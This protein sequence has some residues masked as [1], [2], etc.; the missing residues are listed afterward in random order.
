MCRIGTKGGYHSHYGITSVHVRDEIH[1]EP[2]RTDVCTKRR[3][4]MQKCTIFNHFKNKPHYYCFTVIILYLC[5]INI[6]KILL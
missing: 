2:G 4:T 6:S 3:I 5:I 1:W